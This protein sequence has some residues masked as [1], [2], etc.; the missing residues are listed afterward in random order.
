[1]QPDDRDPSFDTIDL[2]N[3]PVF[4]PSP[5][6]PY[7]PEHVRKAYH[8]INKCKL[9]SLY[10][11]EH[12]AFVKS[13]VDDIK[14]EKEKHGCKVLSGGVLLKMCSNED[15]SEVNIGGEMNE[16]KRQIK[17]CCNRTEGMPSLKQ[18]LIHELIHAYDHCR[19]C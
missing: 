17:I 1:M 3:V 9:D 5:N 11:L 14:D 12:D 10:L 16:Y 18:T 13:L 2:R 4:R 6:N 7:I 8:S 19:V 15:M